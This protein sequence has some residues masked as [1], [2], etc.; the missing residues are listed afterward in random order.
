[1]ATIEYIMYVYNYFQ[2]LC[3]VCVHEYMHVR[4]YGHCAVPLSS[5]TI[6]VAGGDVVNEDTVILFLCRSLTEL[7]LF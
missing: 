6:F 2:G 5:N 7:L 3:I 4:R 1:M